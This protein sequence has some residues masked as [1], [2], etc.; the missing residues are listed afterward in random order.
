MFL[1]KK[2]NEFLHEKSLEE[3]PGSA[4][5][6]ACFRRDFR[7]PKILSEG[8]AGSAAELQIRPPNLACMRRHFRPPNVA[9]PATIKGTLSRNGRGFLPFSATTSFR[10]PS[11]QILCSFTR[12]PPSFLSFKPTLQV[13]SFK[14]KFWSFGNSG[15]LVLGSPS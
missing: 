1:S 6:H 15:A 5:E 7:R 8:N 10:S 13:L 9:W 12:S 11:P 4:A 3:N 2:L 14:G